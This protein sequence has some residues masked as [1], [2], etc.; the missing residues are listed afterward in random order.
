[1]KKR[2]KEVH[3]YWFG[4]KNSDI[5]IIRQK[6]KLWFAKDPEVDQ[7]IHRQFADLVEL[8]ATRQIVSTGLDPQLQLANILLLDQFTR[9]LY[10]DDPR[11]FASD[12]LARALTSDLLVAGGVELRPIEKVFL[13][14]PLEHSENINDQRKSV[15]L[16]QQLYESVTD[17]LK[18]S[19]AGFYAYAVRHHDIIARFGRFPHRNI[20][21]GRPST[22]EECEFLAQPGSS[23]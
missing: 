6:G 1:M 11:S 22:A 7:F 5:E 9:N 16:F 14:L 17:N 13:Y 12:P 23:F 19:F 15:T 4:G 3:R 2:L 18:E 8:A 10:R 20:I 21:L